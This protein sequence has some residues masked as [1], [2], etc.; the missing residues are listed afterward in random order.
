MW[1]LTCLL[2]FT[3]YLML[4][5]FYLPIFCNSKR[6]TFLII[7]I[8]CGNRGNIYGNNFHEHDPVFLW[9]NSHC[10]QKRPHWLLWRLNASGTPRTAVAAPIHPTSH[11]SP[12]PPRLFC[13]IIVRNVCPGNAALTPRTCTWDVSQPLPM[14]TACGNAASDLVCTLTSPAGGTFD[15]QEWSRTTLLRPSLN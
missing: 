9:K 5:P 1:F 7:T 11:P 14:L 2:P 10:L 13:G 12:H 15:T 4:F 3:V 8:F 6:L